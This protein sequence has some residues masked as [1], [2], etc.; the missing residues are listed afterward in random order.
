MRRISASLLVALASATA[1]ASSAPA[2]AQAADAFYKGKTLTM[3]VSTA[4]GEGF[5]LNGRLVAT[6]MGRFLPGHPTVVTKYM[7]G[8]GHVLAANYLATD[9]PRDGTVIATIAPNIILHQLLDGRGVRYDI[10]K[11]NW[12]GASEYGN[13]AVYAW[14]ATGLKTL[15]DAMTRQVLAGGTGAGSFTV[16]Y[17]TLMNNLLGTKF[18]LVTGYKTTR[19]IDLAMQRGEVEVRAGQSFTSLKAYNGD[20]LREKKI[21]VIAQ[22]G[23][24]REPDFA[25]VA[26]LTDYAKTD[27]ARRILELFEVQLTVGRPFLAPPDVP[28]DRLAILRK[29]FDQ[30]MHDPDFL[31]DAEKIKMDARALTAEA[32]TQI[33]QKVAATPPELVEAATRARGDAV[34]R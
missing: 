18:K 24:E 23:R 33:V 10:A 26:L 12:L 29:A 1:C 2:H 28:A 6:Y 9:A 11:F 22:V 19:D 31:A 16:L 20:W 30:T 4:G 15:H 25:D 32:V 3:V 14:A 27:A 17:P 21:N 34:N 5:G 7:P 13:Q 8:A